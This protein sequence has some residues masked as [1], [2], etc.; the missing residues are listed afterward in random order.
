MHDLLTPC[1]SL[2]TCDLNIL[3]FDAANFD[4]AWCE[5]DERVKDALPRDTLII[6]NKV[7]TVDRAAIDLRLNDTVTR[8]SSE[9]A[10]RHTGDSRVFSANVISL[11]TSSGIDELMKTLAIHVQSR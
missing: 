11:T 8:I 9:L 5:M 3:M 6:I 4:N 2:K 10:R 1:Y 7:D